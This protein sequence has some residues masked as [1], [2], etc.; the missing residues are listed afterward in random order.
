MNLRIDGE[1][2]SLLID[3]VSEGPSLLDDEN[4]SVFGLNRL[5]CFLS[6]SKY[7]IDNQVVLPGTMCI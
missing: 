4:E 1:L 6:W 2:L 5:R 7:Y 3:K